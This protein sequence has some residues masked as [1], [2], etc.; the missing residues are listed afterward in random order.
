MHAD[1]HADVRATLMM[2]NRIWSGLHSLMTN[3]NNES[4]RQGGGGM[5]AALI[6]PPE[7]HLTVVL[8]GT[9]RREKLTFHQEATLGDLQQRIEKLFKID[10][11]QQ[12]LSCDDVELFGAP[13]R[14]IDRMGVDSNSTVVV[15]PTPLELKVVAPLRKVMIFTNTVSIMTVL[16]L[17]CMIEM[18]SGVVRLG[19]LTH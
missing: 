12:R 19:L 11:D 9:S 13:T 3:V 5:L 17:K 6:E 1:V 14:R 15:H 10:R 4:A 2:L 7:V 16:E 18:E 8:G